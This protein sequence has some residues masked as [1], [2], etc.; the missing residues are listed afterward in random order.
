M[1]WKP[2]SVESRQFSFNVNFVVM[3]LF[4]FSC[5]CRHNGRWMS[6]RQEANM[7]FTQ[8]VKSYE[9]IR[10]NQVWMMIIFLR[11]PWL[12]VHQT[13]KW[14]KCNS[15]NGSRASE[16]AWAF[17]LLKILLRII[18]SHEPEN[19]TRSWIGGS[20]GFN[21]LI[22]SVCRSFEILLAHPRV[23]GIKWSVGAKVNR[24]G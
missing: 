10:P 13:L 19:R 7:F 16:L 17:E 15:Q 14:I 5:V 21:F 2:L 1:K 6:Q 12:F 20:C 24:R 8:Y 4:I 9:K 3:K 22:T 23:C 18:W 11:E